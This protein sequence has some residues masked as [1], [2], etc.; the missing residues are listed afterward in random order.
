M[1]NFQRLMVALSAVR[2]MGIKPLFYLARYQ[3]GLRSGWTARKVEAA[4][5]QAARWSGSPSH[6]IILQPSRSSLQ[7]FLLA[8]AEDILQQSAEIESG[9]VRLFGGLPVQFSFIAPLKLPGWEKYETGQ[10]AFP[11][12]DVKLTWEP[13]RFGFIFT[14]LR[15]YYLTGDD[16]LPGVFWKYFEQ[17]SQFN[18]PLQGPNWVSAQEVA[19]RLIALCWAGWIFQ[20][21]P[22]STEERLSDL[23]RSIAAHAARI[24]PT[25]DYAR[26][27]GNNHLLSEAAGIYTAAA[28]L[29][30]HPTSSFWRM[31]G[32][33]TF[34]QG[35]ADQ[36][37]PDGTYA[38]HSANYHRLMLDLSL[39][40]LT[41]S[42]QIGDSFPPA[43]LE[44]LAAATSWLYDLADTQSGRVPNLGSNDG[45]Q[46]LPLSACSF[47][48]FRPTLQAGSRAFLGRPAFPPGPW[49]EL[50][51]WMNLPV[52]DVDV[53]SPPPSSAIHKIRNKE[54]WGSI[55][56]AHFTSRPNHADQL[57]VDLWWNG[58]PICL[59]AGT[60]RYTAPQPWNNPLSGTLCHN[61]ITINELDQMRRVGKFLW[62][63]W[64]QAY[65][66]SAPGINSIVA[67][68][69][70]W[71]KMGI[72]HRRSLTSPQPLE[73]LVL[74]ELLPV[75]SS[76]TCHTIFLHWLLPNAP[77]DLEDGC[78][79][80]QQDRGEISLSL[81]PPPGTNPTFQLIQ[82]GR[83]L[84]GEGEYPPHLGW[85]SP[86]YNLKIPAL[87][88]RMIINGAAPL[89][90]TSR[91]LIKPQIR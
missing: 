2:Q 32:W 23:Y 70:A 46:L 16:R 52:D 43:S 29:P 49:D 24:P 65:R 85:S 27:Q 63:D 64:A 37:A 9:K 53:T 22:E 78:L 89:K 61:T 28:F 67:E 62:L 75:K 26:A 83:L 69:T 77:W 8:D 54:D 33:K 39:W 60:Y 79:T 1:R 59:D 4:C 36:I 91:W 40:M 84:F 76:P 87:S 82:A 88:F 90:L 44:H 11:L 81:Q 13:A 74:D 51:I 20:N 73:W 17:F 50:S 86:T 14:L 21:S 15:A 10:A 31:L 71:R 55:R 42:R 45:A 72:L 57:H 38:Q 6:S 5:R 7:P 41:V 30:D 66:L 58:Q 25:L 12:E 80:I 48:D 35:L 47:Q 56:I 19:L 34:H 68:T 18:P 3:V